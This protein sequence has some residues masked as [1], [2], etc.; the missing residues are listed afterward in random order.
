MNKTLYKSIQSIAA[1]S[2]VSLVSLAQPGQSQSPANAPQ[3]GQIVFNDPTPPSQ[4]SPSGRQRGGASRGACHT[5]ESL[6]ALVPAKSGKVWGQT[7]S[8]RPAFWFYL[9]APLTQQTLIEFSV[10][11]AADNY[12]YTTRM[13]APQ[14]K[15]GLMRLALP[16]TAK[17]LIAGQSYSWTLSVYCD[18]TKPSSSVFVNGT[19]QRIAPAVSLQNRL[20]KTSQLEQ[21]NL[22]A[23][24]G[25]WYEA[26]DTLAV[27]YRANPR[28]RS[29][30]SAWTSLLQQA[31]LDG[32]A[33]TPFSECCTAQSRR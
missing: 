23:A 5:F 28:D 6:T 25:I 8:D 7:V 3:K 10:Q 30:V 15:A 21:V 17:P 16:A 12:V 26:F 14:T 9:P 4:G 1:L 32:L 19:I 20:S 27:L 29:I 11:D 33:K 24:N 2:L 13:T 22:Y 31:N 18:P